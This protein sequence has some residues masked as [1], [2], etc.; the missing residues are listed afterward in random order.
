MEHLKL[1]QIK[2]Y[3]NYAKYAQI[4]KRMSNCRR[5]TVCDQKL[6]TNMADM[7]ARFKI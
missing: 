6:V 5:F 7:L 4:Q 3:L 1:G 2:L